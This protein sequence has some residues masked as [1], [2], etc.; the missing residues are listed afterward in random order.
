M[1]LHQPKGSGLSEMDII[2]GADLRALHVGVVE[3]E[4]RFE[5]TRRWRS[6][7]AIP[8]AMLLIE[9]EGGTFQISR[10]TTGTGFQ[11]DCDKYNHASAL[12]YTVLRFTTQDILSGKAKDVLELWRSHKYSGKY[13]ID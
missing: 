9:C 5:P 7:Y 1:K 3:K 10:H 12:G 6:D 13:L 8:K 2:L 11:N 4:Y